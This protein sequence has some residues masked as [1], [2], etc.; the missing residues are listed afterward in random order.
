[1]I[2]SAH[3]LHNLNYFKLRTMLWLNVKL[4][5]AHV[6]VLLNQRGDPVITYLFTLV[7]ESGE[8]YICL[9]L[10]NLSALLFLIYLDDVEV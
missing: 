9:I 3:L 10:F 5:H 7:V 1:M 2:F 8:G 6:F 4:H